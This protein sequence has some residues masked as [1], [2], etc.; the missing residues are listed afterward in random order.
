MYIFRSPILQASASARGQTRAMRRPPRQ[1]LI[2][3]C[4]L[5]FEKSCLAFFQKPFPGDDVIIQ[6][7]PREREEGLVFVLVP[8]CFRFF[9]TQAVY[10]RVMSLPP[11]ADVRRLLRSGPR[12]QPLVLIFGSDNVG[13]RERTLLGSVLPPVFSLLESRSSGK[14]DPESERRRESGS[15]ESFEVCIARCGAEATLRKTSAYRRNGFPQ[16]FLPGMTSSPNSE[17][18]VVASAAG[19]L[20]GLSGSGGGRSS[21]ANRLLSLS[22]LSQLSQGDWERLLVIEPE[23]TGNDGE[24]QNASDRSTEQIL[25]STRMFLRGC[26]LV[27]FPVDADRLD[28][29]MSL[30]QRALQETATPLEAS[31]GSDS[32][33]ISPPLRPGDESA[34]AS[35]GSVASRWRENADNDEDDEFRG[36]SPE[37]PPPSLMF[38]QVSEDPP[39]SARRTTTVGDSSGIRPPRETSTASNLIENTV[40]VGR[41]AYDYWWGASS[42]DPSLPD[43]VVAIVETSAADDAS[44]T[45][46]E[47]GPDAVDAPVLRTNWY[48]RETRRTFR[49]L[50]NTLQRLEVDTSANTA[51]VCAEW[52]YT[53]IQSISIENGENVEMQIAGESELEHLTMTNAEQFVRL[54]LERAPLS[55]PLRVL[56]NLERKMDKH[57][58]RMLALQCGASACQCDASGDRSSSA[59]NIGSNRASAPR[60]RQAA[61]LDAIDSPPSASADPSSFGSSTSP[62]SSSSSSVGQPPMQSIRIRRGPVL[63]SVDTE[64]VRR[65]SIEQWHGMQMA[66]EGL[67]DIGRAATVPISPLALQEEDS[68]GAFIDPAPVF[69][70]YPPSSSS[71]ESDPFGFSPIGWFVEQ[72]GIVAEV[73]TEYEPGTSIAT[74]SLFAMTASDFVGEWR[75]DSRCWKWTFGG[76][77]ENPPWCAFC[78]SVVSPV[79][80]S[81]NA[82]LVAF[83]RRSGDLVVHDVDA[84][85]VISRRAE[86]VSSGS[87]LFRH[88]QAVSVLR[89][90]MKP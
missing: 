30:A 9:V 64:G 72:S 10:E 74:V 17:G 44:L 24:G 42:G 61:G 73:I 4:I 67:P 31:G 46:A 90:R 53:K 70:P 66:R 25:S 84:A 50:P 8:H 47:P 18:P 89:S 5:H 58:V 39:V 88:P 79:S 28:S 7:L 52:P 82:R 83:A 43:D 62:S 36:S 3:R 27:F 34:A 71:T 33:D 11:E 55:H 57:G 75:E 37:A 41:Q 69:V 48:G 2:L 60:W 32:V 77:S 26:G 22:E 12:G 1:C 19:G 86:S 35:A 38:S 20:G 80:L 76:T 13:E 65:I 49:F 59:E 85:V 51:R 63:F 45:T 40:W 81:P 15:R 21:S 16:L 14:A 68:G 78:H 87:A 6:R 56:R 23:G 54:T 29:V